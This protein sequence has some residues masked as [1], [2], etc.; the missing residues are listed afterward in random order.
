MTEGDSKRLFQLQLPHTLKTFAFSRLY[1]SSK[2]IELSLKIIP[3]QQQHP[4]AI[5]QVSVFGHDER[6]LN[7]YNVPSV[8]TPKG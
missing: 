5:H 3:F 4:H 8:V 7:L 2:I 6:C 1:G